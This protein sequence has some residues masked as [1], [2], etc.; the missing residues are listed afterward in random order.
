M[1]WLSC[2]GNHEALNQGVGTI[3]E[4]IAAALVGDR[5]PLSLPPSFDHDRALQLFTEQPEAFMSGP[6]R[7]IPADPDRRAITKRDFVEAHFR[8]QSDPFGHGFSEQNRL[9]ATAYYVYDTPGVRLIALDTSCAAG[10]AA[11]CFDR[12]Q[13]RWL[14]NR[15]AEVHSQYRGADGRE[16][17]TGNEDRLVVLFSHH[18]IDT[19]TNTR[20]GRTSGAAEPALRR[21]R[22]LPYCIAS[23]TWFCG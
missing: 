23:A 7:L 12:D 9:D 21:R 8:P 2:F 3:T 22:C 19:L 4:E 6:M 15:L 18:G 5:K 14:E 16:A 17:R 1:P 20:A 10:G 11:G 13:A